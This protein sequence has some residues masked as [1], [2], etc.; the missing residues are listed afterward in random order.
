MSAWTLTMLIV[1]V[2]LAGTVGGAATR[3]ERHGPARHRGPAGFVAVISLTL[4][5]TVA[6]VTV[7]VALLQTDG[8]AW[9]LLGLACVGGLLGGLVAAR[10]VDHYVVLRSVPMAVRAV[11]NDGR[12]GRR[13][14]TSTLGRA[15]WR[16]VA[17]AL[18]GH[19]SPLAHRDRSPV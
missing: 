3:Y 17:A 6:L 11:G 9:R 7:A 15:P 16:R 13:G 12:R 19:A 4:G 8:L 2:A 10:G 14:V 18:S 1:L 5:G